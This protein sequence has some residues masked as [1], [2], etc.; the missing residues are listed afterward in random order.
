AT[1]EDLDAAKRVADKH[2]HELGFIVRKTFE[3]AIKENRLLVV[4]ENDEVVGFTHF[5]L[6]KD[7]VAII[8]DIAVLPSH[9]RRGYGRQMVNRVLELAK[10]DG[11]HC[12]I[13]RCPQDL[14]SNEFYRHIGFELA[15]VERGKKRPLNIWRIKIPQKNGKFQPLKGKW[16]FV[17][18]LQHTL[19][20]YSFWFKLLNSH[21]DVFPVHPLKNVL[22]TAPFAHK[23]LL[24]S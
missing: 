14:P 16:N 24:K 19:S 15:G 20:V 7:G 8:Y 22:L 11:C 10:R 6:R 23:F 3:D 12:L 4:T 5:R 1:F 2:R 9:R 21:A 17:M 13:L 18:P